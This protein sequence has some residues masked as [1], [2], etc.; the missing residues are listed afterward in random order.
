MKK[1]LILVIITCLSLSSGI[2]QNDKRVILQGFWWNYWNSNHPDAW[3]DYL[4][5]LSTRLSDVGIDA[6]WIPPSYKNNSP[7]STGYSPFDHYDLGDKYQKGNLVTRM[8]NKDQLLR[9]IAI[10]HANGLE[11]HQDVVLNHVDNAG[12]AD[13]SGGED[14]GAWGNDAGA[15]WKNFRY[16]SYGSPSIDETQEDYWSRSGRWSK[17]WENFHPN[18]NH[19]TQDG[20]W[21]SP[22]WGPD[23]CFGTSMGGADNGH[24]ISSNIDATMFHNPDQY[25]HY[26]YEQARD[27][28]KWFVRQT[29]VDGFRWDAVKHFAPYVMGGISQELSLVNGDWNLGEDF[30]NTGEF[31]DND[32]GL[33]D[34]FTNNANA[35][36]GTDLVGTF[37]FSLR[38]ALHQMI[39]QGGGY[40]LGNLPAAQQSQRSRTTTWVENHDTF[41]PNIGVGGDYESWNGTEHIHPEDG[42]KQAAYAASFAM[43]GNHSVF[44]EDLFVLNNNNRLSHQPD[45]FATLVMRDYLVNIIWCYQNLDFE[46]GNYLVPHQSADHL[47]IER[48]NR[49]IIG[50]TDNWFDQQNQWILTSFAPGT[51]LHDYS[52]SFAV[53]RVVDGF[54]WVEISTPPCDGSNPSGRRGY[55]I[56]APSGIGPNY[57]LAPSSTTQEWEMS[58]DLGDSHINSLRQG[59]S[60]PASTNLRYAGSIYVQAGEPIT[61]DVYKEVPVIT[62]VSIRRNGVSVASQTGQNDHNIMYIP[63]ETGYYDIMIR[64][65]YVSSRA[66]QSII[67]RLWVKANYTAPTEIQPADLMARDLPIISWEDDLEDEEERYSSVL[68]EV[69]AYPNPF[70]ESSRI[71]VN[72]K[73]NAYLELEIFDQ[74]GNKLETIA[75]GSFES[76]LHSFV[77]KPKKYSPKIIY[78]LMVDGVYYS[79]TL[80]M[81]Q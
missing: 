78:R 45:D 4:A 30:V 38:H 32:A 59:G 19:N 10:M 63:T 72:L 57:T 33:L 44:F 58:D 31:F 81:Q 20:D 27:W 18:P 2:A 74:D 46:G 41:R 7:G 75:S 11:V 12:S 79:G 35:A 14:P 53:D 76:G 28:L 1:L 73:A 56:W 40:D 64:K 17:N 37:D 36:A 13:G 50:I 9:M 48:Q 69:Y 43:D 80:I 65:P 54:G 71:N 67:S 68:T 39:Q 66:N 49:A 15:L 24:G 25:N 77:C 29:D 8:G 21:A 16:V 52:G 70:T 26:N 23:F 42:R 5:N 22:N 60:L 61:L 6:V 62:R 47:I 34:G 51:V 55:S 3:S